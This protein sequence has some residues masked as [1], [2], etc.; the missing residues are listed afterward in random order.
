MALRMYFHYKDAKDSIIKTD[1]ALAGTE[2]ILQTTKISNEN[3]ILDSLAA[4]NTCTYMK[5][6]AGLFTEVTLPIDEIFNGHE[7]DSIMTAKISF[8]RLNNDFYG[9]ALRIPSYMMMIPKDS[10]YT[11]FESK[12]AP[13]NKTTFYA[14]YKNSSGRN[15][16]NQYTFSNI[17]SLIT[18]LAMLK[19]EGEKRYGSQWTKEH[20]NWNKVLLV[21]VQMITSS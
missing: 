4:I 3:D 13:D 5:A 21:P 1:V 14:S 2:E 16:T 10:L 17:S 11:F 8:Q 9:E 12:L 15:V 18:R 6:P 19:R 7:Q 20:K